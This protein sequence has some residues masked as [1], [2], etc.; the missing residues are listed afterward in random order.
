[1]TIDGETAR[2]FDDAIYVE[3]KGKGYALWVAIADVAHY[4]P[5][6]SA[7]DREA[8]ERGNSYYFPSS[9]EPMFPKA[10]SNGL[11]S[12]NPNVPRLTMAVRME[13]DAQGL[14]GE[15]RVMNAVINS[16][17]R[18]TYSRARD[19]CVDKTAEARTGLL[20]EVKARLGD[21]AG[22][23]VLAMLDTGEELARKCASAAS[24]AAAWTSTC[25]KARSSSTPTASPCP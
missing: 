19:V 5:M 17:A 12:L 9:V 7:L 4:V 1:V 10:L 6:G 18:L 25:P 16:H 2:D 21:K 3:R 11:C 24:N 13:V 20:D 8:Y 15:A 22:Q 14:R 23:D